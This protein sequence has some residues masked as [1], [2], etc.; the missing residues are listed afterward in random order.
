MIIS[1]ISKYYESE[2]QTNV[3]PFTYQQLPATYEI[4]PFFEETFG[5][6]FASRTLNMF[7]NDFVRDYYNNYSETNNLLDCIDTEQSFFWL[8]TSYILYNHYEHD[9]AP[10]IDGYYEYGRAFGY[11]NKFP[12]YIDDVFYDALIKSIPSIAQQQD[13]INYEQLAGMTGAIEYVNTEGKFDEF[14]DSDITGTKNRLYYLDAKYGIENYTRSQ[15]VSLATYFIENDEMSMNKYSTDLQDLRLKQNIEIPIE[16]FNITDYPNI[17]DSFIDEIIPLLYGQVRRSEAIPVNGELGSG[18]TITF[19]QALL[20][21]SLGTVQVEIDD[22][23]TNRVPASTDLASGS[24]I[25][26]EANGRK[27]NGEP[28]KCRVVDSIGIVNFSSSDIIVDMNERFINVSYNN[29]LYNITEWE[30]EEIQLESMG[31]VFNEPVKLYDAIR[32]VQAGSNVGFRYDIAADGRRTIRIDDP[33][34]SAISYKT[35]SQLKQIVESSIKS[36]KELLSGIVKVGY[37]KDYNSDKYLYVTNSDYQGTVLEN[38]REQPTIEIKTELITEAQADA[39]AELY[40]ARFSN[41]PRIVP[42][43]IMGIDSYTLRIYDVIE[44]ELTLGFVNADTGE[45]TGDR[46]FFGVWKIQI[47]GIDPNFNENEEGN[48][49]A[50]YLIE[51]IEPVEEAMIAKDDVIFMFDDVYKWRVK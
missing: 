30:T 15:L 31:I 19:R 4:D 26:S 41:M 32:M 43:I 24:F 46:E 37:A 7:I 39:R 1:E 47:L 13:L 3:A 2:A 23:W 29:S 33:E 22:Q 49:I 44:V 50:A 38:Y 10:Y 11:N 34:R 20:L 21:T 27:A 12:I 36:K 35:R 6:G 45:I 51:K 5:E 9:Y 42:L 48:N 40:A 16:V 18:N 25:L 14:I 28:Y 17:N 8:A